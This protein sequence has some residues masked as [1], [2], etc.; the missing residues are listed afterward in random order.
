MK[1]YT[2]GEKAVLPDFD[3]ANKKGC[4]AAA[5]LTS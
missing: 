5:F 4:L 2:R 1:Y 3:S